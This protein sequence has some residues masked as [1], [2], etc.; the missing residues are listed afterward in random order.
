VGR[1]RCQLR[2]LG[3]GRKSVDASATTGAAARDDVLLLYLLGRAGARPA[4]WV[5]VLRRTGSERGY[6]S[7][8]L[9]I[10][11]KYRRSGGH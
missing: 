8:D 7:G 10:F 2:L 11:R 4:G 6:T 9:E 5:R 1:L 3:A